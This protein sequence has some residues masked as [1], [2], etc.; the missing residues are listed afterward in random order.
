MEDRTC[1]VFPEVAYSI[2]GRTVSFT[3]AGHLGGIRDHLNMWAADER[4]AKAQTLELTTTT[5]DEILERAQAPH[6]LHYVT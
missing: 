5:M 1:E 4:L 2:P 3:S 6:Y